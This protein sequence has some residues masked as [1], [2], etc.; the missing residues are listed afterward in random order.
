MSA[1]II[2]RIHDAARQKYLLQKITGNIA[3]S[4]LID[5]IH[6]I[7]LDANPRLAKK[8]RVTDDIQESL[9]QET[10]VFQFMTK[11]ILLA[12]SAVEELERNRYRLSFDNPQLEGILDGGHNTLGAGRQILKDVLTAEFDTDKAES[13]LKQIKTWEDLKTAWED[14]AD[15]L[16]KHKDAVTKSLMPIEVIFPG[17]GSGA[18][19]F[20]QEK[21]LVINAARNN[22]AELTI[23]TKSNKR[24]FYDEIR[25][26]LD[27]K[28]VDEVEWKSNDGGRIKVRD[29]VALALIPLSTLPF[30]SMR[31]IAGSSA[32]LFSSK[33]QCVNIYNNLLKEDGVVSDMNAAIVEIVNP[34]V[35]SALAMMS[36]MPRLF[37]LIYERMPH[38][39]NATGGKFGK[40]DHVI[41]AA[42]GKKCSTRY[43]RRPVQ[44][45]YG[46]GYIYPLVFALSSLIKVDGTE[47]SWKVNP[48]KFIEQRLDEI[49]KSFYSMIQ[50]QNYDPGK[51]GKAGGAYNLA[52]DMFAAV[53]FKDEMQRAQAQV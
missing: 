3:L 47:V 12:A 34:L 21:V 9:T 8:G 18:Y 7:N 1:E 33:G 25:A 41:R 28:L 40:I 32:I 27:P 17:E 45:T 23:E 19:D 5:L 31:Q 44:F 29:L 48:D 4:S 11:G 50:G 39:Y 42:D 49:M 2:V 22:N 15:L 20:F 52:R 26:N 51:V 24:G 35:K 10:D 6:C 14:Y 16:S 13:L 43:Y 38:S 30:E 46:E 36:D 53:A 37:D